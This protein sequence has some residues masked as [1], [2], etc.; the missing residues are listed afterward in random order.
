M[1]KCP[2]NVCSNN[3]DCSFAGWLARI[4]LGDLWAAGGRYT[5]G[6]DGGALVVVVV[7]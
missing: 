4:K 7:V 2:I 5:K 1:R 6:D 3:N